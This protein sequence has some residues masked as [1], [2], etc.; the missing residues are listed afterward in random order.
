MD[1]LAFQTGYME[2]TSGTDEVRL[3]LED[4]RQSDLLSPKGVEALS[5]KSIPRSFGFT[6]D[7]FNDRGRKILEMYTTE[8]LLRDIKESEGMEP[9]RVKYPRYDRYRLKER[10]AEAARLRQRISLLKSS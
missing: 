9:G 8:D 2:K 7:L 10:Q 5:Q 6:P 4:L 1:K 3:A